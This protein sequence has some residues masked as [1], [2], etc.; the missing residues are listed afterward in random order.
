MSIKTVID[1]KCPIKIWTEDIEEEAV[2][3][4]KN[5][6]ELPFVYKH[7]AC[8]PDVHAGAGATIGSVIPTQHAVIPA[9]V[10]VDLGCGMQAIKLD[11]TAD[12]LPNLSQ[13]RTSIEY[14]VPHGRSDNG[15]ASDCGRWTQEKLSKV[16]FDLIVSRA[17][18]E[19]ETPNFNHLTNVYSKLFSTKQATWEHLGTLGTGNHFIE[20]CLD[21]N[22]QVWCVVHSGSRGIGNRIGAFFIDLAKQEMDN[23]F[24][25]LSDRNLAFLPD[26]S[27]HFTNYINAVMWA[28]TYAR[29]NR[30]IMLWA[31]R[32]AFEDCL[33]CQH[34]YLAL[35]NH[36]K[37]NVWVTRKGAIRAREGDLGII[38]GSM[39]ARTYIVQGK[40]NPDSFMSCSHGAGRKMSRTKARKMFS[41][42]DLKQQTQGIECCKED[43]VLDEIPGAYK[44]I[45]EVME[46]QSD[47]V[48]IKH[49]LHQ[50]INIKG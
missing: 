36:F 37:Q 23:W 24:I 48:S 21:E 31:V 1:A 25:K 26:K 2:Q 39:G 27:S 20:V 35:E 41:V 44:N 15:G 47:L 33:N 17:W 46:N 32:V 4:L 28:Q 3:Q 50:I 18:H 8:M 7:I 5:C 11:L 49:T 29:A 13:L 6:A 16:S 22:N 38:P 40:G 43:H 19:L 12:Q 30:D 34:N 10:G 14:Y 42:E 9:A 45:D